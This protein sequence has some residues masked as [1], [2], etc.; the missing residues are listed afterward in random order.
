MNGYRKDYDLKKTRRSV[1]KGSASLGALGIGTGIATADDPPSSA[2]DGDQ[3]PGKPVEPHAGGGAG[4]MANGDDGESKHVL[5]VKDCNPWYAPANEYVLTEMG[6]PYVVINSHMLADEDLTAYDA[7][8]VPS[9][10][11]GTYYQRL[12]DQKEQ[13]SRYVENGGTLVGHIGT[14]GYPCYGGSSDSILP[15]GVSH[16]LTYYESMTVL[17]E[18]HPVLD[19]ISDGDLDGWNY[20]THGYLTNVPGDAT[21]VYGV[22]GSPSSK[23]T[24]VEYD[25]GDG[26]VLATTHTIEWPW[27]QSYYGTKA[28]LRNELEYALTGSYEQPSSN[29]EKLVDD[30]LALAQ[31]ID[32]IAQNITEQPRVEATLE[33]LTGRVDEGSLSESRA[34][35]AVKRM[36]L[37][38]NVS[39]ATLTAIGPAGDDGGY[40]ADDHDLEIDTPGEI[41][42]YD[43]A[44][45]AVDGAISTLVGILLSN[46]ALKRVRRILPGW[47]TDAVDDAVTYIDDLIADIVSVVLGKF[48]DVVRRVRGT[49]FEITDVLE[50]ILSEA[51]KKGKEKAASTLFRKISEIDTYFAGL[52]VSIFE[53]EA[54]DNLDDALRDLDSG[55]GGDGRVD[56][57]GDFDAAVAD[58]QRG[59]DEIEDTVHGAKQAHQTLDYATTFVDIMEVIGFALAATGVLAVGAA[60][61]ELAALVINT[62][63][64]LT[65]TL[66]GVG[67]V[68]QVVDIHNET[69]DDIVTP[70][71]GV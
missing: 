25:H 28:L 17:T 5:V 14:G 15:Q 23:P 63:F 68:E 8:V 46:K 18:T 54:P 6:V 41:E 65:K 20:S 66:V 61:I 7:V 47:A 1:L 37:G 2:G 11:S 67:S 38:E 58:A 33:D 71:G 3:K 45:I 36:I 24:Y 43:T 21:V 57:T 62:L 64:N 26:R 22:S 51:G 60:A 13:L 52:L 59:L 29:L 69:L 32:G 56:A 39:E 10:Q 27:S 19:G 30:K 55:L 12:R 16:S 40:E 49:A 53:T 48:D 42:S 70:A 4:T 44:E 35:D 34:E 50:D 9:T 31:S